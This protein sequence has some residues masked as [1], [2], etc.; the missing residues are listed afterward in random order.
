MA[1]GSKSSISLGIMGGMD[2]VGNPNPR[3][4][5][6]IDLDEFMERNK[7][8]PYELKEKPKPRYD[9]IPVNYPIPKY[10]RDNLPIFYQN[11]QN[12]KQ[13]Q[14]IGRDSDSYRT[15][16]RAYKSLLDYTLN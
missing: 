8:Q 14:K 2:L 9:R 15:L 5:R 11:P 13:Y 12:A 7:P 6:P 4:G 16:V 1:E 10:G 3:V